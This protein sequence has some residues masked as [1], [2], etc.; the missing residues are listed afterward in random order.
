MSEKKEEH[1]Y[2][3][4]IQF[5][6]GLHHLLRVWDFNEPVKTLKE[7]DSYESIIDNTVNKAR[8]VDTVT[9]KIVR[10]WK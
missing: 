1:R 2:L 3:V 4:Q 7:A 6:E 9:D 10:V 5:K 8:V